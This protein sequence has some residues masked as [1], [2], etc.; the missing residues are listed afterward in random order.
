[1]LHHKLDIVDRKIQCATKAQEVEY[2]LQ[3]QEEWLKDLDKVMDGIKEQIAKENTSMVDC[4][5][6]IER[7]IDLRPQAE[8][9]DDGPRRSDQGHDT[10]R[11]ERM[12]K[13]LEQAGISETNAGSALRDAKGVLQEA[14]TMAEHTTA[15][16]E[17]TEERIGQ[18][19]L[20]VE[21]TKEDV[22]TI[23]RE[24]ITLK[25]GLRLEPTV[26]SRRLVRA[27]H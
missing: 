26:H 1:M 15:R 24:I 2:R 5:M 7:Q 11:E 20:R 8:A 13:Y 10:R 3:R 27:F 17:A 21:T 19:L 4:I 9:N 12:Q 22:E 14:R 6:R 23:R 18:Q 25:A 16:L